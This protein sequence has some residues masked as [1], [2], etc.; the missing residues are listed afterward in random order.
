MSVCGFDC[1]GGHFDVMIILSKFLLLLGP[2]SVLE[3]G[4]FVLIVQ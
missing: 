1:F 3:Y 4:E 2:E